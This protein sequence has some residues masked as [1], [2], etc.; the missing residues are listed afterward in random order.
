MSKRMR[1]FFFVIC[2]CKLH[3]GGKF[4]LFFVILLIDRLTV[5]SIDDDDNDAPMNLNI[6]VT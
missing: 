3:F 2:T 4:Y 1:P 5:K 6:P